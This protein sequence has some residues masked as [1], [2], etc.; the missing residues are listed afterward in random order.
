[1]SMRLAH[2]TPRA[3]QRMRFACSLGK[4]SMT[5]PPSRGRKV[6]SD[7]NGN[8]P[9]PPHRIINDNQYNAEHNCQGIIAHIACL[10]A[11]QQTTYTAEDLCY[12]AA[13][14][15]EHIAF[16]EPRGRSPYPTN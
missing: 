11:A 2:A 6:M 16:Q 9:L 1:M 5:I 10:Q 4:N 8:M 15:I 14:A 13:A 3:V 12:S 7:N